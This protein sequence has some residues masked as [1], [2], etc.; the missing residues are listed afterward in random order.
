MARSRIAAPLAALAIAGALVLAPIAWAAGGSHGTA[1]T[2]VPVP[3]LP[4]ASDNDPA[5]CG[6]PQ[7]MGDGVTGTLDGHYH[8][9]LVEPTVYLYDSHLRRAVIG[10]APSGTRVQVLYYQSNPVLDYY[11]VRVATATGSFEGWVPAP[12]L[13]GVPAP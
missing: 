4:F 11:L 6:I 8:G 1:G 3:A 13:R 12:F 9:K 7:P 10:E 5:L 2:G